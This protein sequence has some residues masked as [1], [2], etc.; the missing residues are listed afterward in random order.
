MKRFN[1]ISS[2]ESFIKSNNKCLIYF[3]SPSCSV[4]KS[5]LPKIKKLI[6]N[7]ES[8][9]MAYVN[10]KDV[11][12]VGGKYS[13]FTMPT[14]L[15]FINGKETLRESRFISIP[16]LKSKIERY[17]KLSQ[18]LRGQVFTFI[19]SVQLSFLFYFFWFLN[20]YY[21]YIYPQIFLFSL[22]QLYILSEIIFLSLL[23]LNLYVFS[24]DK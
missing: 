15:F 16:D 21:P 2:I 14:I 24:K 3:S 20:L 11:P 12:A 8:I 4:C 10:I 6:K 1:N 18:W 22:T 17:L 23:I 13:I 7:Y 19:H 5:L 9:K